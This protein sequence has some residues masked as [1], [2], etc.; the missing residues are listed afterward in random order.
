MT[1]KKEKNL[2]DNSEQELSLNITNN[3]FITSKYQKSSVQYLSYTI[4]RLERVSAI[5]STVLIS[6]GQLRK[7]KKNL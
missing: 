6:S 5:I 4:R 1:Y 3:C 7:K 2:R